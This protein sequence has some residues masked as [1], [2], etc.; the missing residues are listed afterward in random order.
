MPELFFLISPL[1]KNDQRRDHKTMNRFK[2]SSFQP[3]LQVQLF[4]AT[5]FRL[6]EALISTPLSEL[7]KTAGDT[8]PWQENLGLL[9]QLKFQADHLKEG[10]LLAELK[11]MIDTTIQCEAEIFLGPK[12]IQSLFDLTAEFLLAFEPD[13][14]LYYYLL[15]HQEECKKTFGR[16][17]LL[18]FFKKK[19]Q[20]LKQTE[21]FLIDKYQE[22]GFFHL[23]PS[24]RNYLAGLTRC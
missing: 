7:V 6:Q 15:R 4:L 8:P 16:V 14:N 18:N 3:A 2:L 24:I 11:Q 9:H 12:G 10:H 13:E 17:F 5:A 1:P 22:R 19:H 23:K 21:K 20:G